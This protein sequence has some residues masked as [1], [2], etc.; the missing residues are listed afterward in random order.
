MRTGVRA[1]GRVETGETR[2]GP[3][4]S[5][6]D[7]ECVGTWQGMDEASELASGQ[8]SESCPLGVEFTLYSELAAGVGC[9]CHGTDHIRTMETTHDDPCTY[10]PHF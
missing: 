4:E 8:I 5:S 7:V 9:V 3:R 10:K 1:R 2:G 6:V